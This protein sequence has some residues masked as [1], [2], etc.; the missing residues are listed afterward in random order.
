MRH[1]ARSLL[2]VLVV[3]QPIVRV[4]PHRRDICRAQCCASERCCRILHQ[5][6]II[7]VDLA[8]LQALV[9]DDALLLYR[10]VSA[11]HLCC[12]QKPRLPCCRG[13][14]DKTRNIFVP[15]KSLAKS[16]RNAD[17]LLMQWWIQQ[18]RL[19]LGSCSLLLLHLLGQLLLLKVVTYDQ[20]SKQGWL[21]ARFVGLLRP[22][23]VIGGLLTCTLFA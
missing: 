13:R 18:R 5:F 3:S 16:L 11:L 8:F 17:S 7:F 23:R 9:P 22:A 2:A 1:A 4:V 19:R 21:G 12:L 20:R 15:P 10:L 14:I 6:D